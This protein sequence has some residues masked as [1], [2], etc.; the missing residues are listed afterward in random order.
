M[1][2]NHDGHTLN[3]FMCFLNFQ[4]MIIIRKIPARIAARW[5]EFRKTITA[6]KLHW[7]TIGLTPQELYDEQIELKASDDRRAYYFWLNVKA[8]VITAI[9][10]ILLWTT[11]I[12]KL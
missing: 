4:T 5:K 3:R 2:A 12:P 7:K 11:I 6:L 1:A 10:V 8:I 9:L